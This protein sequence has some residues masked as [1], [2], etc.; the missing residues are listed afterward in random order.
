[1]VGGLADRL[2]A[3]GRTVLGPG[4]EGARLEGSKAYAKELC[5]AARIPTA[6]FAIFDRLDD[7]I[8]HLRQSSGPYVIKADGLAGGKG[9]LVTDDLAAAERDVQDK[10]YGVAF[11]EAGRRVVIEQALAGMEISLLAL[12]DGRSAVPLPVARDYKRVGD[13]DE[14]PNTGGMG[15][16][17]PVPRV[18]EAVVS[19]AMDRIVEPALAELARRGVE[20]RGVLY[21]G[22]MLTDDGVQLVEFNVRLGDPE[23]EVILPRLDGDVAELFCAAASRHLPAAIPISDDA[24]VCVVVA[25][26]GYPASPRTGEAIEGVDAADD[27]EGVTVF[28]AG[29]KRE[30]DGVLR[31]AGGRVLAVTG[32][33][34][35]LDSA[36]DRAYEAVAQIGFPGA[37]YRRDIAKD[38]MSAEVEPAL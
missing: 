33:A 31:S 19:E 5:A 13:G 11:G 25:A 21:A 22:L 26:P 35:K 23:A 2:R 28:H 3:Q 6:A 7:A 36:R 10:L 17:S 38:A 4:Q 24:A 16:H 1:L 14:G 20:Y 12:C 37:T 32:C 15:A 27:V 9:V 18:A 30:H 34:P 29:T 8:A